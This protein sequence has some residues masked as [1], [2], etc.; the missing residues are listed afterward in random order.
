VPVYLLVGLSLSG[1]SLSAGCVFMPLAESEPQA[2][3]PVEAVPD[4]RAPRLPAL[5]SRHFRIAPDQD[6]L[7]EPQVLFTR[8]ENTFS[9]IA[10]VYNLGYEELKHAN[11]GVDHWLPGEGTPIVLP[12]QSILPD[13]PR[14]GIVLNL[15]SMRL[16]YFSAA[17]TG[18]TAAPD[19]TSAAD[20]AAA[21]DPA[22]DDAAADPTA[23]R[24]AM[25]RVTSHPIGIGREGW[26]TPVGDATV[27]QKARDPVWYV[28]A[29]VRAEHAAL[30]DPLPAVV[31]PG[32]DN[33]LGRFALAL[34]MPGYLIHGTNKPAGVGMR[35]SHGCIRLYPEDVEAL[36]DRVPSG[37]PVHIVNQPVLAGWHGADLYLEVHRPLVEDERD[38]AA[39]VEHVLAA[40]MSRRRAGGVELNLEAVRGVLEE[41]RGIP[42]PVT[43]SEQSLQ[44]YLASARIVEN[45]VPVVGTEQT[46]Q[47]D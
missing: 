44:Q 32:P 24:E 37:T 15:P 23:D 22:A 46:A 19:P 41:Q 26:A 30:G 14:E 39:E 1:L 42:F 38:L 8:H 16:L 25:L 5:E 2:A 20:D 34:S 33:P 27:T 10:R 7:G 35:V 47:T 3:A 36:F 45:V 9:A 17:A 29:S 18:A 11:P 28:P 40:A 12:T 13:A 6:V 21:D 43:R 4:P 31:P